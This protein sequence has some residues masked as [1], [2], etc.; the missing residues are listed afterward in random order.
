MPQRLMGYRILV[1]EDE[2]YIG[3]DLETVL[4]EEG[5]EVVGPARLPEEARSM[6]AEHVCHAAVL[7]IKLADEDG[8]SI[9][10]ALIQMNVPFVFAT[11]YGAASIPDRFKAVIRWEKPYN[12]ERAVRDLMRILRTT[13]E[14]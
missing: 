5:A 4:K 7:D 8:F 1:V 9:A 6:L 11:G 12:F 10:D 14:K 13:R 3:A 2:Y